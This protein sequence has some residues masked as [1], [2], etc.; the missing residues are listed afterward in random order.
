MFENPGSK[1]RV[2][3]YWF[4]II[5][6]VCTVAMAIGSLFFFEDGGWLL[7]LFSAIEM[8]ASWVGTIT[9]LAAADAAEGAIEA[10]NNTDRILKLL[11]E[12][13]DAEK[14]VVVAKE[15]R[16]DPL[17]EKAENPTKAENAKK[18]SKYS[19]NRTQT[20]TSCIQ[21]INK[22]SNIPYW[23]GK[24][25]HDG[26]YEGNCPNCGSSIKVFHV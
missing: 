11:E 22:G 14:K 8:F 6:L 7:L 1:L 2:L 21:K 26:P 19:D 5:A 4:F 23:C 17:E 12:C 16:T 25:G 13:A 10:A 18:E 24:C 15:E 20:H 3:A 9:M